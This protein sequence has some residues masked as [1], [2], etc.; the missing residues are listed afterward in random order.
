MSKRKY[1][2][3]D[4][5]V[6]ANGADLG[7]QAAKDLTAILKQAVKEQGEAAIIVATGNS[8]LQFMQALRETSGIA[9]DKVR[10]FHMDEYVGMSDT[11][12]ASFRKYIRENLTDIV[13]PLAF[14]GVQGDAPD[15][16][17]ELQRYTELLAR[18]KPVAVVM[19]IGENGHLA[20]ND[21]PADFTT[22]KSIHVVT[23]DAKCRQQQVGEGHFPNLDAVPTHALSLTISELVKPA[24][25]LVVVPEQRKAVAVKAALE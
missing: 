5:A 18:Y 21:P 25:L 2:E 14:Y 3:A 15:L 6:Y 16:E 20:F 11:H 17:A 23:L 10:V 7:K 8:Q 12:S 22:D 13:R 9:W 24:H 1:G 19:G 4:V